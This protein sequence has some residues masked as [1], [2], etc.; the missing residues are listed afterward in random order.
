MIHLLILGI[1]VPALVNVVQLMDRKVM[2]TIGNTSL[3]PFTIEHSGTA[4]AAA[5]STIA[6][7]TAITTPGL[8]ATGRIYCRII[9]DAE[10]TA[11]CYH[12]DVFS[13]HQLKC[14][15]ISMRSYT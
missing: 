15:K 5:T 6:T 11:F 13:N 3:I 8:V 12:T 1:G 2:F 14:F 9:T 4:A 7:L 10:F